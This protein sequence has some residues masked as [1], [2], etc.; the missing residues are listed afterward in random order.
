MVILKKSLNYVKQGNY[1]RAEKGFRKLLEPSVRSQHLSDFLTACLNN[2]SEALNGQGKYAEAAEI[3]QESL[4]IC[5]SKLGANH[6]L[7]LDAMEL[8][9][10]SYSQT[11]KINEAYELLKYDSEW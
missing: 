6:F 3:A 11:R 8:L 9:A 2:L 10:R 1:L 4:E 7:T 5:R